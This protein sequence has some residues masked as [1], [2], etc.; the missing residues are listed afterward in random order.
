MMVL[1]ELCCDRS[2][3]AIATFRS[4]DHQ[5]GRFEGSKSHELG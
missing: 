1:V 3:M 2:L 5:T 4:I